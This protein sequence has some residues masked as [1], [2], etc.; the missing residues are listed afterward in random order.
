MGRDK[1]I[2]PMPETEMYKKTK[3]RDELVRQH[4]ETTVLRAEV[5]SILNLLYITRICS[6]SEFMD[7]MLHQLQRIEEERRIAAGVEH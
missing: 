1:I 2:V 5:A 4:G 6:P 7:V 3:P